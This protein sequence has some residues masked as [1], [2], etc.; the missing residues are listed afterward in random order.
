MLS[1]VDAQDGLSLRAH[2]QWTAANRS[3]LVQTIWS[4]C[5]ERWL[6][7]RSP[8]LVLMKMC[9]CILNTYCFQMRVLI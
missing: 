5:F 9:L 2:G 1:D 4:S 7:S 3:E 8:N 6:P